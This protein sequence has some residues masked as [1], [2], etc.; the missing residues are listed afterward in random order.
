M[1]AT[2]NGT[3]IKNDNDLDDDRDDDNRFGLTFSQ[4]AAPAAEPA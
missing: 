1:I 4:V 3:K 2:T